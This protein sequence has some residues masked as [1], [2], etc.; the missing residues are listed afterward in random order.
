MTPTR[1]PAT[2]LP[3]L[4]AQHGE[5]VERIRLCYGADRL[6]FEQEVLRVIQRF[7]AY[8]HLLPASQHEAFCY[9]GGLLQ[10]SLQT[11]FYSLQGSDAQI[12]SGQ[13]SL[14]AR[15]ELEPRWRLATLI[16]GLCCQV[17]RPL[18][19]MEITVS[20]GARWPAAL[21]PLLDWLQQQGATEYALRWKPDRHTHHG[22]ALFALPHLVP[23]DLL[24]A[25]V[26][27]HALII[28]PL[29]ASLSRVTLDSDTNPI[30]SLV[31]RAY[32]LVIDRERAIHTGCHRSPPRD[33]H[34]QQ[35][36]QQAL[37][38]LLKHHGA[39]QPNA[40]KSR[41]WC[42]ADGVFMVWPGAAAE[43]HQQ[44][45]AL[46][47]PNLPVSAEALLPILINAGVV[48]PCTPDSAV[49]RINPPGS[50][51]PLTALKLALPEGLLDSLSVECVPLNAVSTPPYAPMPATPQLPLPLADEP[52]HK[53]DAPLPLTLEAPLRL[54]PRVQHVLTCVLRTADEPT[55]TALALRVVEGLFIPLE[56]LESQGLHV[57][58]AIRALSEA[59]MLILNHPDN[60]PTHTYVFNGTAKRGVVIS[61]CF[62]RGW[63]QASVHAPEQAP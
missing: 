33:E 62:I 63:K 42:G 40:S 43:L 61:S 12:F 39:W 31:Q 20:T 26:D 46:L 47:A 11:A 36:L 60:A 19:Q 44:L 57:A 14:V 29:L 15:R 1:F 30:D 58:T 41:V 37:C 22:L 32:A 4:L 38:Q 45:T 13:A 56:V 5:W 52:Q 59:A 23:A 27:D 55:T 54:N 24:Q 50:S 28:T 7:A 25:L 2:P 35:T 18:G 16:A 9:P 51:A 8:V 21:H 17:H 6:R 48:Q 10:L 3:A 49:W 34:L 53:P